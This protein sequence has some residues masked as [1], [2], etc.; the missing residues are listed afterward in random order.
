MEIKIT[1]REND[2]LAAAIATFGDD[3]Q[4]NIAVEELGELQQAI[5]KY[6][7]GRDTIE[8]VTEEL[9]DVLIIILQLNTIL[10]IDND[11][12]YDYTKFKLERLLYRVKQERKSDNV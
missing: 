6:K 3:N 4:L 10:N 12:L 9:A 8:H 5:F 7:R 11:L 2:I 1:D